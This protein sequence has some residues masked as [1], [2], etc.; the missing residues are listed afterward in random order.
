MA[1]CARCGGYFERGSCE[2]WKKLCLDCWLRQKA[3][4]G[5]QRD[6]IESMQGQV[7]ILQRQIAY[8]EDEIARL[9]TENSRLKQIAQKL[10]LTPPH[11]PAPAIDSTVWRFLMMVSHP[12]RNDNS[13]ISNAATRF[14]LSLRE[15]GRGSQ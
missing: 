9:Q 10:A 8:A 14:L 6:Q 7:G 1:T 4:E 5:G 3:N 11:D 12:D 15:S 2:S 13:E